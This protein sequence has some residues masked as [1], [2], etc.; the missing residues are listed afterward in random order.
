[1]EVEIL[2]SLEHIKAISKRDLLG[3]VVRLIAVQTASDKVS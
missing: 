3:E 2:I 1:M